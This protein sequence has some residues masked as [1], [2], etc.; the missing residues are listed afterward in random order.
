MAEQDV[1]TQSS[2]EPKAS[3]QDDKSTV[4]QEAENE[5]P[6]I[7]EDIKDETQ[8]WEVLLPEDTD[9]KMTIRIRQKPGPSAQ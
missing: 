2:G 3:P 5:V 4:D 6:R 7:V 8:G 9:V 1:S